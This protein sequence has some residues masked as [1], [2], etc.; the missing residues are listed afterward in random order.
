MLFLNVRL[1]IKDNKVVGEERLLA[2]KGERFRDVAYFNGMLYAVTD[3]GSI[4]RI[5]KQ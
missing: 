1:V 5:S 3:A 2:D 4:Y